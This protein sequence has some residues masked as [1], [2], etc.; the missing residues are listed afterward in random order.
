[1]EPSRGFRVKE[2]PQNSV[3]ES[4]LEEDA[5]YRDDHLA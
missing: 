1:M 4:V 5:V 3:A 2:V